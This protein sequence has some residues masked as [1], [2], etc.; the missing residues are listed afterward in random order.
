MAAESQWKVEGIGPALHASGIKNPLIDQQPVSIEKLADGELA[1]HRLAVK[2]WQQ[3]VSGKTFYIVEPITLR[4]HTASQPVARFDQVVEHII[5]R[6]RID[7]SEL[8]SERK[9]IR[10]CTPQVGIAWHLRQEIGWI[11]RKTPDTRCA[12]RAEVA[13]NKGLGRSCSVA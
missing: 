8:A 6:L 7:W 1:C 3:K 13:E 11:L 5:L 2:K 12:V 4:I 10:R 9:V